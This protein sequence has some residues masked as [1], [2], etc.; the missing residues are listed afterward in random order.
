MNELITFAEYYG[1][2]LLKKENKDD[3]EL[4]ERVY[5]CKLNG[6]V[7]KVVGH[8]TEDDL[9]LRGKKEFRLFSFDEVIDA[10]ETYDFPF[11]ECRLLPL[12]DF[13]DNELICYDIDSDYWVLF[14]CSDETKYGD[15]KNLFVIAN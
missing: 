8:L 5:Q 15:E 11:I 1:K 14:D 7:R 6:Q 12:F 2:I 9:L 13:Y 3:I 10:E 4:V